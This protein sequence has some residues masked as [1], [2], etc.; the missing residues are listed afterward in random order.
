MSAQDKVNTNITNEGNTIMA[1]KLSALLGL[2][3]GAKAKLKGPRDSAYKDFQR[4][5]LFTGFFRTYR[6]VDEENGERYPDEGE[7]VQLNVE[8]ILAGLTAEWAR[9]LD[10]QASVDRTNQVAAGQLT[11]GTGIWDLPATTLVWLDKQLVDL[12]TLIGKAP[13]VNPTKTWELDPASGDLRTPVRVSNKSKKI[14][15]ALVMH[16]G[17]DRHPAQVQAYQEDVTIGHWDSVDISGATTPTRKRQ[18]LD[19]IDLLR[20][21]VKI[22]LAEANSTEVIDIRFGG[23]LLNH[24]LAQGE[25]N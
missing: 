4:S 7:I 14:P 17:N 16:P 24:I 19:R 12:H 6:P 5:A 15:K 2:L 18:I 20:D 11:I 1:T 23:V 21:Q 10:L 25:E 13:E 22:A 9:V 3:Q 8:E